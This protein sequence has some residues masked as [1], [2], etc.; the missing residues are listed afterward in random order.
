VDAIPTGT[1]TADA[2]RVCPKTTK[3]N[4][5]INSI[6]FDFIPDIVP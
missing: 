3:I 6:Y 1:P 4:P 2:V 5:I